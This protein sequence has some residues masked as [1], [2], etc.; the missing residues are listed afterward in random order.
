MIDLRDGDV[1][2]DGLDGRAS[3]L[4]H[5]R[6]ATVSGGPACRPLTAASRGSNLELGSSPMQRQNVLLSAARTTRVW[7]LA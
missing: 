5:R 4:K 2:I 3:I 7:C 6:S 1:S